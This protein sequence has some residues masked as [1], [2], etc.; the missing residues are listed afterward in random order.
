MEAVNQCFEPPSEPLVEDPVALAELE[1][2]LRKYGFWL[3]FSPIKGWV[4]LDRKHREYSD[5]NRP[6]IVLGDG[7]IDR[8][9]REEFSCEPKGPWQLNYWKKIDDASRRAAGLASE[10]LPAIRRYIEHVELAAKRRSKLVADRNEDYATRIGEPPFDESL[11]AAYGTEFYQKWAATR[12]AH[13]AEMLPRRVEWLQ[14]WAKKINAGASGVEPT[15][16]RGMVAEH[17][18]S[19]NGVSHLWHFTD[20]RNLKLILRAGGLYSWAGLD[21]L[22][23]KDAYM[24]ANDYSRS[25]DA[26]LGR[27][28]YVRLS[29]IPN[30]WFFHRVN[31]R[32]QTVWLRFSLKALTLGEIAYSRGNAASGFVALEDD[33]PLMGIDWKMVSSFSAPYSSDKGPTYY[34]TLFRDQVDDPLL[35]HQISSAWNSEVLIKHYLPLD[36]CTGIFDCRTGQPLDIHASS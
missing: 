33:L 6:F 18:L 30:S 2:L 21:A 15:W 17:H 4:L 22:G 20:V 12:V 24:L 29:F 26:R 34:P 10:L 31:W 13:Y 14:L 19:D 8:L 25:C 5:W 35:F 1:G 23:I 11:Y 7:S 27:E 9:S 16:S 3:G 36:F 32:Q 28:R